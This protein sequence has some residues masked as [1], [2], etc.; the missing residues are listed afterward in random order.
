M[1]KYAFLA[2]LF[3]RGAASLSLR[4]I[5][6]SNQKNFKSEASDISRRTVLS[7]LSTPFLLPVPA[8]AEENYSPKFVQSYGDFTE[9]PEGYSYK[10]VTVGNGDSPGV[11]DRAV[12]DWSGYTIG[13]FGRPFEAKG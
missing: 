4:S 6:S 9:S 7:T 11:G 5:Y 13:Y 3:A 2:A 12:F 10:D 1:L 8:L